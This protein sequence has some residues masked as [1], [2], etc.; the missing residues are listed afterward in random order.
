MQKM[1]TKERIVKLLELVFVSIISIIITYVL[2]SKTVVNASSTLIKD[3]EYASVKNVVE[4]QTLTTLNDISGNASDENVANIVSKIEKSLS[5]TNITLNSSQEDELRALVKKNVMGAD[6]SKTDKKEI[7]KN[8]SSDVITF[9]ENIGF[10]DNNFVNLLNVYES[11]KSDIDLKV[12]NLNNIA[13]KLQSEDA[14]I[15][16][17]SKEELEAFKATN[18]DNI[19]K[20]VEEVATKFSVME[21]TINGKLDKLNTS[22][23]T[24]QKEFTEFQK[25]YQAYVKEVGEKFKAVNADIEKNKNNIDT[26]FTKIGELTSDYGNYKNNMA[27]VVSSINSKINTNTTSLGDCKISYNAAD[28]HFYITYGSG[29]SAVTK[30][31]DY[32]D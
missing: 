24:N 5:D 28:G 1:F 30:K 29:D 3:G 14:S 11:N 31:L 21:T 4:Y 17:S 27:N 2:I 20:L 16:S 25:E 18:E 19:V 32:V 15:K 9:I 12:E 7:A 26:I 23:L 10:N 8:I 6:F 13:N 22:L